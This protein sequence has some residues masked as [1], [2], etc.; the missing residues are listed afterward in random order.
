MVTSAPPHDTSASVTPVSSVGQQED[1]SD[2][3]PRAG[4][5]RLEDQEFRVPSKH[6]F[7]MSLFRRCYEGH[8]AGAIICNITGAL[9]LGFLVHWTTTQTHWGVGEWISF[10]ALLILVVS[11]VLAGIGSLIYL[12]RCFL[13]LPR[14]VTVDSW[15]LRLTG[16]S[17]QREMPWQLVAEVWRWEEYVR[18]Y[19]GKLS[20]RINYITI[21]ADD[22]TSVFFDHSL[23]GYEELAAKI[24]HFGFQ[25]LLARK[26]AEWRDGSLAF[27]PL[28]LWPDR[29]GVKYGIMH[30]YGQH[31]IPWDELLLWGVWNGH[32]ILTT[33]T[34]EA[35]IPLTRVPNYKILLFML[36][37]ISQK[38]PMVP[39]I[40]GPIR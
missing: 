23:S 38:P 18:L 31:I 27:G 33:A 34:K 12:V 6:V 24:Q 9:F 1:N 10:S 20:P 14:E 11:V 3:N 25:H 35:Q 21:R 32:L 29:I 8:H 7:R 39:R 30:F 40:M 19:G 28:T 36:E 4:N 15:G 2:S 16:L 17:K 37:I 5:G 13:L 22:G 26:R